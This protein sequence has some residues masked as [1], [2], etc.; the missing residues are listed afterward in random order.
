MIWV[1]LLAVGIV[2]L[3]GCSSKQEEVNK[4]HATALSNEKSKNVG[5]KSTELSQK[6]SLTPGILTA[7]IVDQHG[8]RFVGNTF[9]DSYRLVDAL[10]ELASQMKVDNYNSN[11]PVQITSI[12]PLAP[13][14]YKLFL[15]AQEISNKGHELESPWNCHCYP[16][17][18]EFT[19]PAEGLDLGEVVITR[20]AKVT[21]D[22]I[23]NEVGTEIPA[24]YKY[25]EVKINDPDVAKSIPNFFATG[26]F[27][28]HKGVGESNYLPSGSYKIEVHAES[29]NYSPETIAF[30]VKDN[31]DV[32]LGKVVLKRKDNK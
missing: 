14:T 25:L 22:K 7:K 18:K 32:N 23:V 24:R 6:K 11:V 8:Q 3:S 15:P 30:K 12:K 29:E 27:S 21:I 16:I 9:G 5:Q 28:Y 13:G 19:M 17:T 26:D 10:G 4:E 2:T 31:E 20:F 1:F